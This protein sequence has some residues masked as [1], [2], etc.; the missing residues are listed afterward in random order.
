MRFQGFGPRLG[1]GL[2]TLR[3][4]ILALLGARPILPG[5]LV[6]A[7]AMP[8]AGGEGAP[9]SCDGISPGRAGLR[10]RQGR[11]LMTLKDSAGFRRPTWT[12]RPRAARTP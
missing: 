7:A 9:M 6:P 3:L 11:L 10:E 1:S 4:R 8:C 2:K 12:V 5:L